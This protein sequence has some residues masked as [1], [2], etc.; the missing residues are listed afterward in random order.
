MIAPSPKESLRYLKESDLFLA[1]FTAL[2]KSWATEWASVK[3]I[4]TCS[5]FHGVPCLQKVFMAG[6]TGWRMVSE[7]RVTGPS[8]QGVARGSQGHMTITTARLLDTALEG[9][10]VLAEC[11]A[12]RR[13]KRPSELEL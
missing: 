2:P 11:I 6:G 13:E 1:P 9:T 3:N 12:H 7:V 10:C 4:P 8:R 5:S